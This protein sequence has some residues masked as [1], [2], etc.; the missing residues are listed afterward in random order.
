M[1][2]RQVAL[3]CLLEQSVSD[4]SIASIVDNALQKYTLKNREH[5]FVNALVYGVVRWQHQLDWVL[6]QFVNPRFQLD[7]KRRII[8]RL[9]AFQLLHLNGIPD[10][11]AIN[12]TVDLAIEGKKTKGFINAVLRSIQRNGGELSYPQLDTHPI[13]HISYS[14]S[15]PKWLVQR[16][17]KDRGIKWT[18]DFCIAS[19]QIAP[20]SIR[21][22]TLLTDPLKLQE[23]LS[24]NGLST[25]PSKYVPEGMVIET[26][27][28]KSEIDIS[29]TSEEK[30]IK[31]AINHEHLYVQDESGMLIS[32]L[33]MSDSPKYVVDL[34]AAP[35][36]KTTHM[37]CLMQDS[38][39]VLAIDI[40]EKKLLRIQENCTRLG[41]KNVETRVLDA[42]KSDLSFITEVDAVL[43]D[44][45]CS[46]FGT[47]RR[48]PDIRWNKT[49]KQ[50]QSLTQLQYN[51][52]R[53]AAQ[54]IKPNGI[55]VYS[56]CTIEKAENESVVQRF[57]KNYPMF[58]IERPSMESINLPTDIITPEGYLQ[59]LPQ[60]HGI[61]GAF[62]VKL[63]KSA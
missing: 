28:K 21:T 19:N 18:L 45:P 29:H 54:H 32:H 31:S 8:L 17:I 36:G 48:H 49:F 44:A 57:L 10:R 5:R 59:T 12:E 42:V 11:A 14:Y 37:A 58:K 22:N 6:G 38:G 9:G 46:G 60:V 63:R 39:K 47:L 30:N 25:H 2:A 7:T 33:M 61:D 55:L 20:I 41:I 3:E 52:L 23:L 56:T 35:G 27:S 26:S 50:L 13:D 43:I 15:Y 51:L 34:C 62:A 40:S 53:N 1:N 24:K 4:A 16:W